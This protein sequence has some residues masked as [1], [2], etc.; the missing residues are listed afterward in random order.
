MSTATFAYKR[1]Y[2]GFNYRLRTFAGSRWASHCR[3]TSI[4]L[5]M[6]GRC[7]AK[8]VHCD[9]WQDRGPEETLSVEQWSIV[10]R[11][12]REWLGPVHIVFTGGEALMKSF[13]VELVRYAVDLGLIVE[14]LT[15]G[16]WKDQTRIERLARTNPWRI[17][18]SL[19]GIGDTHSQIRGHSDFFERTQQSLRTL[20]E[21]RRS[22]GLAFRLRLKTVVMKQNLSAVSDVA[23]FAANSGFEVFYQPIEQNYNQAEDPHWFE[24]SDTWPSDPAKCQTVV[25]ELMNLKRDGLPIVNSF[26]Q[27]EAME[28][29]FLEPALLRLKTQAH[30]AHERRVQCSATTNLELRANGNV[31]TC[32]RML[33]IGNVREQPIRQIWS[34]RPK[35]WLGGCCLEN[36]LN[37][38]SR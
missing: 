27:L 19:D 1:I 30:A 36:E 37:Q 5:A 17:T 35:W 25:N 15:N 7:N 38:S 11:D 32:A 12:L 14:V 29:Y 26:A 31:L 3:P 6:T 21:L 4:A 16:Y 28:R 9:I 18:V 34:S 23:R 2:D 13:T 20:D 24:H 10:L 33:P 8:C 22:E